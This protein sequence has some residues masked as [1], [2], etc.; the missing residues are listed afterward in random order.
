MP[1]VQQ[2]LLDGTGV[3]VSDSTKGEPTRFSPIA[4]S[5]MMARA[6]YCGDHA[7][8]CAAMVGGVVDAIRL[9]RDDPKRAFA[10]MKSRFGTYDDKVL[11][12]SFDVLEKVS[13]NPPLTSAAELENGD[14]M[15]V[16]AGFLK[17]EEKL[18]DYQILIDNSFIK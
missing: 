9:M 17:S 12:A 16:A 13:A 4:A 1:Y 5:M 2:V 7:A 8:V 15:N 6:D 10:V 18:S 14:L 11:E 3:L